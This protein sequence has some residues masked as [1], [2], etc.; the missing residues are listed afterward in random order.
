M[1]R[2]RRL[3]QILLH[4]LGRLW[5]STWRLHWPV[6]HALPE[7]GVLVLWHE[8]LPACIPAFA[9][10]GISVLISRSADG[11]LAAEACARLGY[12]VHRGSDSAG[13]LA[14]MKSM[15]RVLRNGGLAGMALDGPRGPRRAVKPGTPWLADLA[16]APLL[17]IA[18][19]ATFAVRLKT[20][21]RCLLP[22]PFARIDFRV[23]EPCPASDEAALRHAMEANQSRLESDREP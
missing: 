18:V 12:R 19:K 5:M 11:A 15:V 10:R 13:S 3:R 8:H 22:L 9:R 17:P 2:P 4:S 6:G 16:G 7:K 14:G 23:G 1:A 20:W 21:D